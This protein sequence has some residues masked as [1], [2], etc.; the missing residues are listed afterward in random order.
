M[1]AIVILC[2]YIIFVRLCQ[3]VRNFVSNALKFTPVGGSVTVKIYTKYNLTSDCHQLQQHKDVGP[4]D[5][6]DHS[7]DN[8]F[9][10]EVIDSGPGIPVVSSTLLTRTAIHHV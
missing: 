10:L 1:V 6:N 7:H 9:R 8:T 4:W 5:E 2:I 3:V